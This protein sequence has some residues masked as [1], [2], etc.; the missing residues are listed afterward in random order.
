MNKEENLISL[1]QLL[2]DLYVRYATPIDSLVYSKTFDVLYEEL[3]KA[4]HKLSKGG[5]FRRLLL[6]RK[7]SRL[8]QL[9]SLV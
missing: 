8:P 4:G 5:V 7:S 3:Q 1:D 9:N 2:I 6:L